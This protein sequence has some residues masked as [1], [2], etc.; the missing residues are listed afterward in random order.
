MFPNDSIYNRENNIG[1]RSLF[2]VLHICFM[3]LTTESSNLTLQHIDINLS[4]RI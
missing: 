3:T 4:N 1:Q 2:A